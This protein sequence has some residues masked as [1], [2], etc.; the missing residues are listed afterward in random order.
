[1]RLLRV[2][3][4][5]KA[6]EM[7][8]VAQSYRFAHRFM[9]R[10]LVALLLS[11][12]SGVSAQAT[13]Q[14][15]KAVS[16]FHGFIMIGGGAI[17]SQSSNTNKKIESLNDSGKGETKAI[18]VLMLNLGYT[19]AH[20]NS[21]TSLWIGTGADMSADDMSGF[22]VGLSQSFPDS[23]TI[24]LTYTPA[25]AKDEDWKDPFLVGVKRSETDTSEQSLAIEISSILGT[26]LSLSYSFSA[27]DID[28]EQSGISLLG[29]R[30]TS[31]DLKKL[32]RQGQEHSI[33]LTY[34]IPMGERML[35]SPMAYYVRAELD[36][37]ANA[38][39]GYG[40]G[41]EVSLDLGRIGVKANTTIGTADFDERHPVFDKT[42]HDMSLGTSIQ[43]SYSE[44]FGYDSLTLN[45]LAGYAKQYS[46]ID[47][48][49]AQGAYGGMGVAWSF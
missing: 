45:L 19:F 12:L 46:N 21:A 13:E 39:N 30:L 36:G 3:C 23:T 16:G 1:M 8:F 5:K 10:L 32:R 35:L 18:P 4:V 7:S 11:C 43:V 41:L 29:S 20:N 48:Y 26:P 47:F 15:D 49:E 24:A 42:R 27:M 28:A 44:L 6:G 17:Y 33:E 38:F 2:G 34:D 9:G 22:S 37:S 40:G 25:I 14:E 31:A